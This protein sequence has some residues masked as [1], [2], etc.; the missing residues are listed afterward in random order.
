MF[1]AKANSTSPA[2][3]VETGHVE[4]EVDAGDRSDVV[5]AEMIGRH[6][7]TG[8]LRRLVESGAEPQEVA[9]RCSRAT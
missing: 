2:P 9:C 4:S 7:E 8:V 5:A 6:I 1:A 3:G